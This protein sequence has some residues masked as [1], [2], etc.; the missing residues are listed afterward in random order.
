MGLSVRAPGRRYDSA[1]TA[2]LG[3]KSA[4]QNL[5]QHGIHHNQAAGHV[6]G[7]LEGAALAGRHG[8]LAVP[9]E[10]AV[11]LAVLI[12]GK[13]G[14]AVVQH[15]EEPVQILLLAAVPVHHQAGDQGLVVGPPQLHVMLVSFGGEALAVDEV[16]DSAVLVVPAVGDGHVK[17]LH[18]LLAQR[19][20]VGV[21]GLFHQEPG[22]LD[23]VAGIHEAAGRDVAPELAVHAHSLQ[24]ALEFRLVV[25]LEDGIHTLL[26]PRIV[27][28]TLL[29]VAAAQDRGDIQIDH[30]VGQSPAGAGLGDG[31]GAHAGG[32]LDETV[33]QVPDKL[34]GPAGALDV[35]LLTGQAVVLGVGQGVEAFG[36]AVAALTQGLAV[37]GDGEVHPVAGL[38]VDAVLLHEVQA[39]LAGLHPLVPLAVHVAQVG[40]RPAAAALHPHA[41]VG[42]E[43]PTGTV[44]A[45]VHAAVLLIHAVLQP[46]LRAAG[47]FLFY[48]LLGLL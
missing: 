6:E 21:V 39:A 31:L 27:Q 20:V 10:I 15:L 36:E 9:A 41:L 8:G 32:V 22:A 28:L 3:N 12:V 26:G 35:L 17:D 48:P 34:I 29:G 46:E 7:A 5:A 42:G 13:V 2:R 40:V 1:H 18:G 33:V 25:I 43:Q 45:G 14:L 11:P 47:Q 44:N 16:Q 24:G 37:G 23:V 4:G 19:I 30:G 38:A